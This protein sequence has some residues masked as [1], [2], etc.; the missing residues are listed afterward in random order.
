MSGIEQ[1]S[2]VT[3]VSMADQWFDQAT[4]DHFWMQ[5]RHQLLVRQLTRIGH[6]V[7]KTVDVGCGHGVARK[8]L[9]RDLGFA[10]DGCDVN[11]RALEMA[12]KGKGRL[13]LYDISIETRRSSKPTTL[14]CLW[15]SLSTLTM[16]LVF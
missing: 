1:L 10:V 13:L 2:S 6:P 5:W 11:R 9:E 4:A 14:Y 7:E 3:A 16:T 15:T 12:T 8:L